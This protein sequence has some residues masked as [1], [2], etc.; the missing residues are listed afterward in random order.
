MCVY[1]QDD[2][3]RSESGW[4]VERP[5]EEFETVRHPNLELEGGALV[6]ADHQG[7]SDYYLLADGAWVA[8]VTNQDVVE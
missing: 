4:I 5:N 1:I 3:V 6:F 2:L 7:G 8:V